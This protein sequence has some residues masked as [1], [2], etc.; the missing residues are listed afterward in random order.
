[1]NKL[2]KQAFT[3]IELLVV[4]AIIGILSGLIVVSMGGMTTKATIA[5]AQV[6]SNSL[7]NSLMLNLISD[8][9][10]DENTGITTVDSWSG[11]NTGTLTGVTHLPTWKTGSNCIS[12]SC[13]QFDGI[14]DYIA[15]GTG[16]NLKFIK[17]Y[18]AEAWVNL[19][20]ISG[21]RSIITK[22]ASY[23]FEISGGMLIMAL[24]TNE[25]WHFTQT[26]NSVLSINTWYHVAG[27]YDSSINT[28]KFYINGD[29]NKTDTTSSTGAIVTNNNTVQLG[30]YNSSFPDIFNGTMDQIRVYNTPLSNSQ[31]KQQYYTGLNNL[32]A[33]GG[34]NEEEYFLRISNLAIN[35]K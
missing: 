22:P 20:A 18:T 6:F 23:T 34:I 21:E 19:S 27:T 3:L 14:D 10:L 7:R 13:I 24:T 30:Y 9:K 25:A 2:I 16:S 1:M 26:A 11:G 8:W 31:I 5:K 17:G 29:L 12:G 28:V 15:I 32:L 33:N 4:I 35:N